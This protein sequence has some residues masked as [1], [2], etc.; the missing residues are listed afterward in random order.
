MSSANAIHVPN[1]TEETRDKAQEVLSKSLTTPDAQGALEKD[2]NDFTLKA[3]HIT[4]TFDEV[5][6]QL[7]QTNSVLTLAPSWEVLKMDFRRLLWSSRDLATRIATSEEQFTDTIVPLLLEVVD[8]MGSQDIPKAEL[9]ELIDSITEYLQAS[10]AVPKDCKSQEDAFNELKARVS[11]FMKQLVM[12]Y[13]Q[14]EA[15]QHDELARLDEQAKELINRLR[16][17]DSQIAR[18]MQMIKDMVV[19]SGITSLLPTTWITG[20]IPAIVSAGASEKELREL[21]AYRVE[22]QRRLEDLMRRRKELL[23]SQPN[24]S[25]KLTSDIQHLIHDLDDIDGGLRTFEFVW[26]SLSSDC[27]RVLAL[28]KS[29]EPN[30]SKSLDL[31]SFVRKLRNNASLYKALNDALTKY[32]VGI[33]NSG[34]PKL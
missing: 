24:I 11:D 2:I 32:A 23:E 14:N 1:L 7:A 27:T 29:E 15:R 16:D 22:L 33:T 17:V 18:V 4:K 30:E 9:Q 34:I 13:E 12:L 25:G 31:V 26:S 8:K 28:L 6:N 19:P 5:Q 21:Q 10:D 20:M 3:K